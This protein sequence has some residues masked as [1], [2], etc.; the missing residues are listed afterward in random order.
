MRLRRAVETLPGTRSSS[1]LAKAPLY[2]SISS[3]RVQSSTHTPVPQSRPNSVLSDKR[4]FLRLSQAKTPFRSSAI[5]TQVAATQHALVTH[6]RVLQEATS[7]SKKTETVVS[8]LRSLAEEEGLYQQAM[9]QVAAQLEKDLLCSMHSLPTEVLREFQ[10]YDQDLERSTD[11]VPYYAIVEALRIALK[12]QTDLCESECSQ[13][14]LDTAN[15]REEVRQR[16]GEIGRLQELVAVYES[17]PGSYETVYRKLQQDYTKTAAEVRVL[18]TAAFTRKSKF[19]AAKLELES[20]KENYKEQQIQIATLRRDLSQLEAEKTRR[21][22]KL[23]TTREILV[24]REAIYTETQQSNEELKAQLQAMESKCNGLNSD[25]QSAI[26]AK[27]PTLTPRPD[28]SLCLWRTEDK[29]RKDRSSVQ[30]LEELLRQI[31]VGKAKLVRK[32]S[33]TDKS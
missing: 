4:L 28:W 24:R 20:L 10:K 5:S 22:G 33:I 16:D 32:K 11:K 30:L 8:L 18:R 6:L 29:E 13:H 12:R 17:K 27:D 26:A 14:R 2:Q 7:R 19:K 1:V 15:Y 3:R 9:L 25:L 23:A 31:E 21:E